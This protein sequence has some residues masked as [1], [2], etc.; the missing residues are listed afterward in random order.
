[1]FSWASSLVLQEVIT[2]TYSGGHDSNLGNMLR[3]EMLKKLK[4]LSR[5]VEQIQFFRITEVSYLAYNWQ[6]DRNYVFYKFSL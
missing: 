3:Y 4:Y 2:V 5:G 6:N 1:M